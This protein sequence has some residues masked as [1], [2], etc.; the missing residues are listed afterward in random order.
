MDEEGNTTS[1]FST[2]F[3]EA[4]DKLQSRINL[5]VKKSWMGFRTI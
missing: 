3:E 4:F 5:K 2:R 1:S